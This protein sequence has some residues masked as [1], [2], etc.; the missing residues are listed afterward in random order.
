LVDIDTLSI[1]HPY[2]SSK[3]FKA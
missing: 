2:L 3:T 1:I